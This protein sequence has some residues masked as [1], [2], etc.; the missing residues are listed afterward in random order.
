MMKIG[1]SET[2]ADPFGNIEDQ[3]GK[4][5]TGYSYS[6]EFSDKFNYY[7]NGVK[8]NDKNEINAMLDNA[9]Q[10]FHDENNINI[11]MTEGEERIFLGRN[12]IDIPQPSEVEDYEV[13][14]NIEARQQEQ[15][16]GT[17][18][19]FHTAYDGTRKYGN[20]GRNYGT[21]RPQTLRFGNVA[22]DSRFVTIFRTNGTQ[23]SYL[24][25]SHKTTK[26]S[27]STRNVYAH[28]VRF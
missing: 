23:K 6:D 8:L 12:E 1:D 4:T 17:K 13:E 10:V 20:G 9:K 14:D 25:K 22:R 5:E 26:L 11:L 28:S 21:F 27:L 18:L 16:P 19:Y 24:I 2:I 15:L 3:I 7:H